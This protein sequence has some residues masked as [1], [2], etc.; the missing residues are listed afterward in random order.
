MPRDVSTA[1][2]Y[3]YNGAN[4]PNPPLGRPLSAPDALTVRAGGSST[5]T[6]GPPQV[7]R[8]PAARRRAARR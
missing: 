4:T 6:P 3:T 5:I 8:W 7:V 2:A 1:L